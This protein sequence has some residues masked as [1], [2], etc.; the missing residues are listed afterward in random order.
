MASVQNNNVFKYSI[1][2]VGLAYD[3]FVGKAFL[4]PSN[5]TVMYM[6]SEIVCCIKFV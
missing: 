1:P 6:L 4:A 5:N 3:S 2:G